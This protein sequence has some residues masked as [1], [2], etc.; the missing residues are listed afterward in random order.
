MINKDE[1]IDVIYGM[2]PIQ[3]ALRAGKTFDKILIQENL[4]RDEINEIKNFIKERNISKLIVPKQKLN[5]ITTKNHQGII[6]FL[7]PIEF[8][9]IEVILPTLFNQG[10]NP[11]ILVLDKIS[12]V[13]NFGAI[14]RT[15]ECAGVH[16]IVIP[17]KGVAQIN[18]DAIKTSAGALYKIPICKSGNIRKTGEFLKESGLKMVAA[19][20]KGYEDYLTIDYSSP[21]ALI[22][23]SEEKGISF[24]LLGL[25]DHRARLPIKGTVTSL[26][27]SVAAGIFMYEVLRQRA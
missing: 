24:D 12:D 3:E 1:K 23:G 6:G 13:R 17:K 19:I 9:N 25:S 26:N 7:C 8:Q 21:L 27:V 22:L 5:S 14:A 18:S 20:E 10:I 11:F 15:A 2:H 4:K 16:A